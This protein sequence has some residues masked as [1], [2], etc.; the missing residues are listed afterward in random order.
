M[1]DGAVAGAAGGAPFGD[2]EIVLKGAARCGGAP[3]SPL[4]LG[5]K[6]TLGV[7]FWGVLGALQVLRG[8]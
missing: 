7:S 6:G 1:G 2:G 8:R 5:V 3:P 4:P